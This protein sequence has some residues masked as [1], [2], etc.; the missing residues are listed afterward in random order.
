MGY[1]L[2]TFKTGTALPNTGKAEAL[3]SEEGVREVPGTQFEPN[4]VCVVENG[5]FDAAGY[6]FSKEEFEEFQRPD[7]RPR[8][9]LI[10]PD[11]KERSA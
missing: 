2:N 4:L 10:V 1:Y 6:C 8:R 11:A 5:L 3:L 9:W 7:G